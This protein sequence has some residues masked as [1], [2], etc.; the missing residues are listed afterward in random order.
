MGTRQRV[1]IRRAE[2]ELKALKGAELREVAE[3]AGIATGGK[4][5]T[6]IRDEL[7]RSGRATTVNLICKLRRRDAEAAAH[8]AD[9]AAQS[10]AA[11]ASEPAAA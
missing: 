5:S 8:A 3:S 2:A 4:S 1:Q 7:I 6:A 11:K 9:Q 10:E